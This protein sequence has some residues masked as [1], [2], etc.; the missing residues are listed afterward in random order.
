MNRALTVL[1][2]VLVSVLIAAGVLIFV[3]V[4][5]PFLEVPVGNLALET[6][7][8]GLNTPVAFAFAPD[9]RIFYNELSVGGIRI[10]KNGT[11]LSTPFVALNVVSQAEMGLLGLA[12]DPDFTTEP[13]VYVFYTFQDADGTF[14]RISRF[15]AN[16]DVAGLEEILLNRLPANRFHNGGRLGFGPDGMLYASLGDTGDAS[17]SQDPQTLPGKILRMHRNGT[18]PGDNPFSASYSYLYG[19]R[20]VFGFDFSPTGTLFFTENGPLGDDEVNLGLRGENYGWP[21]V[22][23]PS[24]DPRFV[25]PLAVFTPAIA[26]TGVGFYTGDRLGPGHTQIPYF[27]SWNFGRL[28]RLVEDAETDQGFRAELVLDPQGGGVLDVVNGPDGYLYVSF[29]DRIARVI[30]ES[31]Q[32]MTPTLGP[33]EVVI[34]GRRTGRPT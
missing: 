33:L 25:R 24:S 13:F 6:V 4:L 5:P 19:I 29:P 14:N 26:P 22:Q 12:L 20:N 17:Q 2:A 7:H 16:G 23:G 30:P 8:D 21:V 10:I 9:G 1:V 32:S 27:G 18:V 15:P 34:P 28:Y 11:V 31:I 3:F